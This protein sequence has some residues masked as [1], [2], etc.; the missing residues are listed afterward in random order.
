ME[1]MDEK[2]N[3]FVAGDAKPPFESCHSCLKAGGLPMVSHMNDD[4]Y[5]YGIFRVPKDVSVEEIGA[6]I[7][8]Y[9]RAELA[10]KAKNSAKLNELELS[11][12][13]EGE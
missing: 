4:N 1:S 7:T 9:L 5:I 6:R 8:N 11:S 12:D 3:E 10:G 2:T 13:S